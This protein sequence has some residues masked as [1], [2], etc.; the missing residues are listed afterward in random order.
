MQSKYSAPVNG[1]PQPITNSYRF[2]KAAPTREDRGHLLVTAG[3]V[4]P[5]GGGRYFIESASERLQGVKGVGY[6]V[7]VND[8][9]CQCRDHVERGS[10]CQHLWAAAIYT[11]IVR[12]SVRPRLEV[13]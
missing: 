5:R 13:A 2:Y 10:T 8:H 1:K 9:T 6:L 4:H 7:D 12:Q 3:A 11:E